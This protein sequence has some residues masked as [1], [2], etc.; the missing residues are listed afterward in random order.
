MSGNRSIFIAVIWEKARQFETAIRAE[1]AKDFEILAE[2]EMFWLR[3]SFVARLAD[4]YG[5]DDWFCWWNKAR[6]CGRGAFRVIVFE[7]RSPE[8]EV[9]SNAYGRELMMDMRVARMKRVCREMTGHHNRFH[10]AMNADET[11][12]ESMSLFGVPIA[13][14]LESRSKLR[15]PSADGL[16]RLFASGGLERLGEGSR[17]VCYRIPDTGLCAKFYRDEAAARYASVAREIRD[18][19]HDRERNVCCREYRFWNE[20]KE[21]LPPYVFAAFPDLMEQVYVP[22]HGW[23]TVVS[24]VQNADGTPCQRF[25]RAY[26]AADG[27]ARRKLLREFWLLIGAF[28]A[29]SVRFFDTQNIVVQYLGDGTFRLRIVDFE[30]VSRTAIPVDSCCPAMVRRKVMRRARRYLAEHLSIKAKCK[31]LSPGLR[32]RWDRLIAVEGAQLGLSDCRAFLEKKVASDIFYEGLYKGRPCIVKCSSNAPYS[33]RNEY[34]MLRRMFSA[35]PSVC[36]EP[37]AF[38]S[39]RDGGMAFV[40]MERLPGPTLTQVCLNPQLAERYAPVAADDF[41]RIAAALQKTG[42]VHGDMWTA[43]NYLIGSDGHFRLTD[44][45]FAVDRS[46]GCRDPW[47]NSRTKYRFAVLS[48]RLDAHGAIWNDIEP[49]CHYLRRLFPDA[50]KSNNASLLRLEAIAQKASYRIGLTWSQLWKLRAYATSLLVQ[51]LVSRH[52]AARRKVDALG[53]RYRRLRPLMPFNAQKDNETPRNVSK[54]GGETLPDICQLT[55]SRHSHR[56]CGIECGFPRVSV[57]VPVY[58]VEKYLRQCI[59]SILNQTLSAIEVIIVDDGSPDGCPQICDEYASSDARVKVLHRKNGGLSSARNAG[60]EAASAPYVMFCDS[61]DYLS[62]CA[63]EELYA[64]AVENDVDVVCSNVKLLWEIDVRR[65]YRRKQQRYFML[66]KEKVRKVGEFEFTRLA[67]TACAKLFKREI[68]L[69]E[70]I[71]F[72]EGLLHEDEVFHRLYMDVARSI[73][74]VDRKLY[75]YR[76]RPASIMTSSN[77]DIRLKR[78]IDY[79]RGYEIV[80]KKLRDKSRLSLLRGICEQCHRR[81]LKLYHEPQQAEAV[82]TAFSRAM[83]VFESLEKRPDS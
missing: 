38:W 14:W 65:K 35:D 44:F 49:L 10:S 25:T 8:W 28:A 2:T 21:R 50:D 60:L 18:C 74:Y 82:E 81:L 66:P 69:T 9:A 62:P 47:L 37:L 70:S 30:P 16:E 22:S 7:D 6:K 78:D 4:F 26:W 57:I 3:S 80:A 19:R 73:A 27:D 42:I 83:A 56:P 15:I 13:D 52:Y 41:E 67:V 59:D 43:D 36:A 17:R 68:L 11:E 76:Q 46:I 29:Y 51:I 64:A 71:R 72:P 40:V 77:D 31:G 24:L 61:D 75:V 23:G 63:C 58:C 54:G 32:R 53:K 55:T 48:C 39:S 1:I 5:K 20:L 79:F 34:N 33:I 45:Q 12:R